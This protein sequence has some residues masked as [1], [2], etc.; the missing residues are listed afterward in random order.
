M[1]EID[2]GIAADWPEEL[3]ERLARFRQGHVIQDAPLSFEGVGDSPLWTP[4]EGSRAA[5]DG[6]VRGFNA[7][8]GIITSQTCNISERP[9]KGTFPWM[10]VSPV[11]RL[12]DPAEAKD[13]LY[14][15]PLTAPTMIGYYAD[16]RLEV[17]VEKSV[18]V[19]RDPI[20][21][22]ASEDE[23]IAF[24]EMLGRQRDRAALHDIIN[25]V[26]YNRWRK[27]RANNKNRARQVFERLHMVGMLI[28]EGTRLEPLAVEC[29]FIGNGGPVAEDDREWIEAWWDTASEE[30]Q[31]ADPSVNLLPNVFH[32]GTQ[33]DV[34]IYDDLISLTNWLES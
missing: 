4:Q 17:P 12:R 34:R 9:P 21:S 10:Q 20:E 29:H 1:T 6:P 7:P 33:M 16:L 25:K 15:Y 26:L 30:A 23:E 32:D 2:D 22:F 27:K 11:Y 8:Y 3:F 28:P 14:L 18:L 31:G 19:G 24:G 13:R 5:G